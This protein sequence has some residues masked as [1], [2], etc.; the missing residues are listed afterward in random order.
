[1]FKKPDLQAISAAI[2]EAERK[3]A[4]EIRV[5]IFKKRPRSARRLSL[6][7]FAVAEFHQLKMQQTRDRT[8]ILIVIMLDEHQF[9]ILADTGINAKVEQIIWDKLANEMAQ[10]FR[11]G[12]YL[13]GVVEC[14]RQIGVILAFYF[15]RRDD[16]RNE[17]SDEVKIA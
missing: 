16:D 7:E 10:R 2:Q 12:E 9:Q 4:G 5:S 1:M 8:G 17:L 15:P 13:S 3:T 11:S 6:M 14:V